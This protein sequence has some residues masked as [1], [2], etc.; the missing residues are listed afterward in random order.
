MRGKP[1]FKTVEIEGLGRACLNERGYLRLYT[2]EL[3]NKYVHRAVW[4]K[5]A[6]RPVPA[7]FEVHHMGPKT[8]W[9]GHNLV[10]IQRELHVK[11]GQRR[12]PYTGEFI[13]EDQFRRRYA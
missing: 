5:I 2:G 9:C 13:S 7:G 4:E 12:D 8:C 10:A 3:R 6:G 11:P 1:T